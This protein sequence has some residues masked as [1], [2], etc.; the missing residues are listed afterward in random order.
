VCR[1]NKSPTDGSLKQIDAKL[2]YGKPL[3]SKTYFS[4][5]IF[6]SPNARLTLKNS[7]LA[8]RAIKTFLIFIKEQGFI[9]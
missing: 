7:A 6:F 3:L 8:H 5:I 4:S 9:S 1:F 2:M